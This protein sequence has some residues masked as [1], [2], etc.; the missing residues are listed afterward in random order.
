[1]PLYCSRRGQTPG[2]GGSVCPE[3]PTSSYPEQ[4]IPPEDRLATHALIRE[5]RQSLLALEG[6]IRGLSTPPTDRIWQRHRTE[7]GALAALTRKDVQLVGLSQA[8][9][10]EA[11]KL[12]P[13]DWSH[14]QRL[15]PLFESIQ[16]IAQVISERLDYLVSLSTTS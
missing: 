16:T 11:T 14:M 6:R 1:M 10:T 15:A 9:D 4:P 7:V 8:L 13:D 5:K 12:T 3:V 2:T